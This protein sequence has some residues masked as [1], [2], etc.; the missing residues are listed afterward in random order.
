MQII[1]AI[2]QKLL[3]SI[4]AMLKNQTSFNGEKFY[5]IKDNSL[6]C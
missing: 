6:T 5:L 4:H 3:H 2:M 1:C